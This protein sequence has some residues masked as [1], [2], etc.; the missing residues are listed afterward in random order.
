MCCRE[1]PEEA[2][3]RDRSQRTGRATRCKDCHREYKREW[4]RKNPDKVQAAKDRWATRHPERA[5]AYAQIVRQRKKASP[6]YPSREE[7]TFKR[8]MLEFLKL[9]RKPEAVSVRSIWLRK[10]SGRKHAKLSWQR[11]YGV[12]AKFTLTYRVR[13]RVR[14]MLKVKGARA[15][16][17]RL[18]FT[19]EQLEARLRET[20]P[21]GY[22]WQDFMD[23]RLHIDH[24]KPIAAFNYTSDT[25]PEFLACWALSNLQLLP[26]SEN[27]SKGAKWTE[28]VAHAA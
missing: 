23:G 2:F 5:V 4:Q 12:D 6:I 26:D 7:A 1:L 22:T 21:V 17:R 14:A 9:C 16:S 20:I 15:Q 27:M 18:P 8:Q 25:D 3:G 19:A 28:G 10:R 24:I 11:R 13:A